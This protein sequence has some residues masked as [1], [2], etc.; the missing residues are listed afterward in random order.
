M[1][2]ISK[3][4]H[5]KLAQIWADLLQVSNISILDNF[6]ELGGHSLLAGQV[7]GR[8]SAVFGVS[9]PIRTLFQAARLKELA[10]QVAKSLKNKKN[11]PALLIARAEEHGPLPVSI[12]QEH[13]LRI[14]RELPRL[15]QFNLPIAHRLQG[16]L[17]VR[18]LKRSLAEVARWHHALRTRFDWVDSQPIAL[19]TPMLELADLLTL[20][21]LAH[22]KSTRNDHHKALLLQKAELQLEEEARRPFDVNRAPLFRARLLRLDPT[23]HVLIFVFHHIIVDGWSIELFFDE[24][25]KLYGT[26]SAGQVPQL[27]TLPLQFSDFARWQRWWCTTDTAARQLVFWRQ[28]LRHTSPMFYSSADAAQLLGSPSTTEPLHLPS[29]LVARLRVIRL[30]QGGTLFMILLTAFKALLMARSGRKDICIATA[31]ANRSLQNTEA[32]IGPFENTVLIRTRIDPDLPFVEALDRVRDSILNSYSMQ[33]FPF[34]ILA[35]RLSEED[36][37]DTAS[38]I[39]VVFVLQHAFGLKFSLPRVVS[40]AFGDMSRAGHP[41]LPIDRSRLVVTLKETASGIVGLWR[42]KRDFFGPDT[43]ETWIADY[44]EILIKVAENPKTALGRLLAR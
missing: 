10:Q 5:S 37:L 2:W 31:M 36:G 41:A 3:L 19:V 8:I 30:S 27:S 15:P 38:L 26:F 23:D 39:Q 42:C 44:K 1:N 22:A 11:D 14:E 34:E 13:V 25:S 20:E 9:L 17:N 21:V 29:E 35:V 12:V 33:E 18:A 6:F 24:L 16:P 4:G 28:Y 43:L 7:L 40:K 32:V